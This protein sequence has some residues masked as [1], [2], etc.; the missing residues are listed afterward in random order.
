MLYRCGHT[1]QHRER[2]Y[3]RLPV[4]DII[5]YDDFAS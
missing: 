4:V 1:G 3:I 2:M 5:K